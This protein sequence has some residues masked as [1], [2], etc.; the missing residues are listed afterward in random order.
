MF[1]ITGVTAGAAALALIAALV[2]PRGDPGQP[3]TP[4]A[5]GGATHVVAA[6]GSGDFT[7]ISEAVTAATEGDTVLVRPGEYV[8][9]LV[10]DKDITIAGDG[11][12]E[13]IVLSFPEGGPTV[14]L[15]PGSYVAAFPLHLQQGSDAIVRSLTIL[16]PAEGGAILADLG[17]PVLEDLVI[18]IDAEAH[19]A[20]AL[21]DVSGLVLRD[22]S[23][24]GNIVTAPGG[25]TLT[26]EGN[27]FKG[28]ASA[29]VGQGEAVVR[30]NEFLDGAG[31][32]F[33]DGMTGIVE[34]N[35]FMAPEVP[36]LLATAI[37]IDTDS[38]M[39]VRANSISGAQVGISVSA[40][41][42]AAI[43]DNELVDDGIGIGW[44]STQPGTIDGNSIRGGQSGLIL[45]AGS[46]VV[47]GN[48]VEDATFRGIAVMRLASPSLGGNTVCDCTTNLWV[49]E[50]AEPEMGDNQICPDGSAD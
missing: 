8:E 2:V 6:D 23:I 32:S 43:E 42:S 29:F 38:D 22:S 36:D 50:Q 44:S 20:I 49:D 11:P 16:A 28:G 12:R 5:G 25:S 24:E 7:T 19:G 30:D 1:G 48:T 39:V 34:G 41:G 10:I 33:S 3:V 15:D 14:I 21:G 40:M 18:R 46:P 45:S 26:I 47:T 17:A 35:V 4:A 9:A 31:L 13:D 27:S 37:S